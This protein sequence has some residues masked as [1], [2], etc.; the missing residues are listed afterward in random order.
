LA[1]II[2]SL[3]VS[4]GLDAS[5]MKKGAKDAS[6]SF[7]KIKK[8]SEDAADAFKRGQEDAKVAFEKRVKSQVAS[9]KLSQQAAK[10]E[11]DLFKRQQQDQLFNFKKD[12]S[13][14]L[15][16]AKKT[17][18]QE[19]KAAKEKEDQGKKAAEGISKVRNEVL[20]LIGAFVGLSALKGFGESLIGL[21]AHAARTAGAVGLSAEALNA[22]TTTAS[23]FGAS[24]AEVEDAFR[25]MNQF[26]DAL[27][28]GAPEATQKLNDLAIELAAINSRTGSH[29]SADWS[30]LADQRISSE[31]RLLEL[32]K[33]AA[34]LTEKD[35]ALWLAKLGIG[36]NIARALHAGNVELAIE[37]QHARDIDKDAAKASESSLKLAKAWNEIKNQV[38]G[39]GDSMLVD[40]APA[41][42]G[43]EKGMTKTLAYS[44]DH[45]KQTEIAVGGLTAALTAAGAV[46]FLGLS[47][48]IG[49]VG[50]AIAA[51][52]AGI[53]ALLGGL[54]LVAG[55]KGGYALSEW[56]DKTFG[57]KYYDK[58]G[59]K[60]GGEEKSA[61][62]PAAGKEVEAAK[63]VKSNINLEKI[64]KSAL[65]AEAAREVAAVA[66]KSA[67]VPTAQGGS[68][69]GISYRDVAAGSQATNAPAQAASLDPQEAAKAAE[70]KYGIPA[71]VTLAQYK[72]ESNNGKK[73]PAGS[74]NPFGIKATRAEIEKGQYVEGM[75]TE[76]LNGVDVRIK[77]KFKKFDSLADAFEA[78]AK[79]L[80]TGS[81]YSEARKH[82]DDPNAFAD[83]LTGK[84]ATDANYGSKLKTIIAEQGG[85]TTIGTSGI[86]AAL[87][88]G[89]PI[90]RGL[91]TGAT[92]AVTTNQTTNNHSSNSSVQA[93]TNVNGPINIYTQATDAKGVA[94]G[95]GANLQ[96]MQTYVLA[97]NANNGLNP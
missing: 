26:Q 36:E 94:Q 42:D 1:T 84:Y 69:H 20:G 60:I 27:S 21:G 47:T 46:S 93:E 39:V 13:A 14:K 95:L 50:T 43:I 12:Q 9:G 5:G 66:P 77:Q 29:I 16:V 25:S 76:H 79:L 22:W 48:G 35:S 44:H 62:S 61:E 3:L 55:F 74:N 4:L 37:L 88:P 56:L 7:D 41:I 58:N 17:R 28:K 2:D 73:T 91:N 83:A 82:K 59:K 70:A 19:S 92:A 30:R 90:D 53:T 86:A 6:D 34:Q 33:T 49:V 10:S 8:D 54:S 96:S 23:N 87:R 71:A 75:T 63:R 31:E 38:K 85:A 40:L 81:A 15:D 51:A 52:T 18:D 65:K 11:S 80:A 67:E 97:S 45:I 64:D 68:A 72:L 89:P 24:A 78:H 57:L 32:S